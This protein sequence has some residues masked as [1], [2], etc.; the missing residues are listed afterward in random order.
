MRSNLLSKLYS[1]TDTRT[2]LDVEFAKFRLLARGVPGEHD[3]L[4]IFNYS[5]TVDGNII[6]MMIR[7]DIDPRHR[8][9]DSN[10][11][12]LRTRTIPFNR[13]NLRAQ[14]YFAP[15]VFPGRKR[16][17]SRVRR[18]FV[19]SLYEIKRAFKQ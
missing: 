10:I 16:I 3:I 11:R 8:E 13:R 5:V 9:F 7:R 19:V 18:T 4:V 17:L 6:R 15:Y 2:R 14:K 12:R 1:T